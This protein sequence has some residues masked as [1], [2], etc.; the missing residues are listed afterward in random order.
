MSEWTPELKEKAKELYL[1]A[2]PTPENS[3][4]VVKKVA[5]EIGMTPNG[6]R[7]ILSTEG[8]YIKK[9]PAAASGGKATDDGNKPKRVSKQDAID[10]L[11]AM[12]EENNIDIDDDI[13]SK[14]TGKAAAYFTTV[15]EKAINAE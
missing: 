11:T 7:M 2:K 14:M 9:T 15:L 5:E 10:K 6:T 3:I 8:V 4:E 1:K 12:L 13:I